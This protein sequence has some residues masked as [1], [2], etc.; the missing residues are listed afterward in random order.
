MQAKDVSVG[1]YF[2]LCCEAQG[3]SNSKYKRV[4]PTFMLPSL[5]SWGSE[6]GIMGV[7]AGH[8]FATNDINQLIAIHPDNSVEL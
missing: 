4:L 2:Y 5:K 6:K 8:I 3:V 7:S 1:G